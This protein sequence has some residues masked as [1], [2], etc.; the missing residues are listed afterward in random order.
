MGLQ[1]AGQFVDHVVAAALVAV[2]PAA[3]TV[4]GCAAGTPAVSDAELV[5][6]RLSY[7]RAVG[8]SADPARPGVPP[9]EASQLR[10]PLAAIQLAG[11]HFLT[12]GHFLV[13]PCR[14]GLSFRSPDNGGR[15]GLGAWAGVWPSLSSADHAAI[16]WRGGPGADFFWRAIE[17]RVLEPPSLGRHGSQG[18]AHLCRDVGV[19]CAGPPGPG[20]LQPCGRHMDA[21]GLCRPAAHEPVRHQPLRQCRPLDRESNCG[22]LAARS[23][24]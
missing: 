4:W 1:A 8:H 18:E 16:R 19:R 5:C 3:A 10:E 14:E 7:L 12:V 9:A 24:R 11:L 22:P 6:R 17:K 20:G 21:A 23:V 2:L 15:P 13:G